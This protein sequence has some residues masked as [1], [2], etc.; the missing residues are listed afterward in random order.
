MI[1]GLSSRQLVLCDM[2]WATNDPTALVAL[3]PQEFRKEATVMMELIML[4]YIDAIDTISTETK[5]LFE[6]FGKK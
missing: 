2:L 1:T 3:M 5:E 4:D 6:R